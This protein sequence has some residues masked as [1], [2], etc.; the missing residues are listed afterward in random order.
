MNEDQLAN[1][2]AKLII[3]YVKSNKPKPKKKKEPVTDRNIIEV[4]RDIPPSGLMTAN[5][6]IGYLGIRYSHM[7]SLIFKRQIPT[8]KIGRLLRF[9]KKDLD[10]WLKTNSRGA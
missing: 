8:I 4:E 1:E 10:N 6:A 5:E 7:R 3:K 9:K 2:I